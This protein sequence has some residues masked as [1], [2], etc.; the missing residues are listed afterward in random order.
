MRSDINSASL[1]EKDYPQ[2]LAAA[3]APVGKKP[4]VTA[5]FCFHQEIAAIPLEVSEPMV[6]MI[7]MQWWRDVLDEITQG[8]PPRPHPILKELSQHS[9]DWAKLHEVVDAYWQL[10]ENRQ[11]RTL[12]EL[13]S[14]I[15][16]TDC[17]VIEQVATA[18]NRP[19]SEPLA[20][21][22]AYAKFAHKLAKKPEQQALST[23]LAEAAAP[24]AKGRSAL[25]V[26]ARHYLK[27][28]NK[29]HPTA[30][31]FKLLT[32]KNII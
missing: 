12:D 26:I 31:A 17:I 19:Y 18:I 8:K 29:E 25:T 21:G 20:L 28:Q 23:Q 11:P 1:K 22:Y 32:A 24:L 6:G 3:L 2:Y 27:N 14:F 7:K 16:K 13:T 5:L 10:L 9:P 4:L 15:K 30:L